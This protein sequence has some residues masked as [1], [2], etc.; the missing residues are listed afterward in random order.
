MYNRDERIIAY[1][2]LHFLLSHNIFLLYAENF[3]ITK[4][5]FPQN[6][7]KLTKELF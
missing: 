1:F 4:F 5:R 6:F 7:A 3:E 2:I